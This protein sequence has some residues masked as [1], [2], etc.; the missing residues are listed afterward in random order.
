M[1]CVEVVYIYVWRLYVNNSIENGNDTS[2]IEIM[3]LGKKEEK[4]SSEIE[5]I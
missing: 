3:G 5:K 2:T 1:F 4:Q